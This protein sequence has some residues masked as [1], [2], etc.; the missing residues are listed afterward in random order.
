MFDIIEAKFCV[1]MLEIHFM[2]FCVMNLNLNYF[3]IYLK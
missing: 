2:T 3:I 1:N